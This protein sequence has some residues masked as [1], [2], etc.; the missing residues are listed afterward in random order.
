MITGIKLVTLFVEDQDVAL[1]FYVDQLGFELRRDDDY[2]DG[3][4][5]IEIAPPGSE[6]SISV[7]TPETFDGDERD[8]RRALVGSGPQIA[9]YVDDCRET[10]RSLREAGVPFDGEPT[11]EPW[12][13]QAV[14]SDPFG[15]DV[16]LVERAS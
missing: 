8:H 7:K 3:G 1:E 12:G 15:T 13:T 9:Y 2:G 6:T 10:Y 11:A 16:V 5:W 4:R 14:A